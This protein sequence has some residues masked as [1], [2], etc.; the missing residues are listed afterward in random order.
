MQQIRKDSWNF[1]SFFSNP[2]LGRIKD[3]RFEDGIF[4]GVFWI[5]S[6]V[7]K[8]GLTFKSFLIEII[9]ST[10]FRKKAGFLIKVLGH[11]GRI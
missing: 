4:F 7:N 6:L 8:L 2:F 3:G 9:H 5:S 10:M 1:K 11:V